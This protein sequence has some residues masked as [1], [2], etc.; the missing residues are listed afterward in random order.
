MF[1]KSFVRPLLFQLDPERVHGLAT[2]G[3]HQARFAARAMES[4]LSVDD[5]RLQVEVFGLRFKNPV[6]LAA[7]FD[8]DAEL[9]P[10]W[11]ALGFGFVELGTITAKAQPGNPRPRLFRLPQD[12]AIINRMGFNNDGAEAVAARLRKLK[13][14]TLHRIPV[15]INIGKSKVT[16][17][18]EAVDDYLFSF[19][20]LYEF[21]D[22]FAVN[23]SSPNTP[24]LRK[25]QD[26]DALA[27]LLG[28]LSARNRELQ[29]KPLLVKIAPDLSWG[30]I[31]DVLQVIADAGL[32][33]IVAT[34]TTIGR[35][36][37]RTRAKRANETGGLSGGP[38]RARATEIIRYISKA[39]EGRL[40]IVGVGGIFTGADAFE[41]LEAGA[42]LVQ[43]YTGFI[44]E[45]PLALRS[46]N[47][48]LAGLLCEK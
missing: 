21:G 33:G 9:V 18:E 22:Y 47:R 11:P 41:K 48:E 14:A 46:I 2:T 17:L 10:I 45:G 34:N 12:K 35:E 20:T 16:P 5:P 39:T 29:S 44:Y 30:Q 42:S 36:G 13:P 43:L 3:L 38:L 31:D 6:G 26:K 8:K 1:Y 27:E 4:F 15:G 32:S 19:N 24:D 7:G 23:V 40:P 37:L 28:A 25:L